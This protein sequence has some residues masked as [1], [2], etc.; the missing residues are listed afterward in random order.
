[1]A[2]KKNRSKE[3]EN[4][5]VG[6]RKGKPQRNK[7]VRENKKG[8]KTQT[9]KGRKPKM[10]ARDKHKK[11]EN[12]QTKKG[13]NTNIGEKDKHEK[14]GNTNKEKVKHNQ[15]GQAKPLP[16]MIWFQIA[17]SQNLYQPI[18]RHWSLQVKANPRKHLRAPP[19]ASSQVD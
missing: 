11:K 13:G 9:P 8:R 16:A 10:E 4:K 7:T 5:Q 14:E 17:Q 3:R 15:K 18:S 2:S 19:T 6:N 12:T 1:M